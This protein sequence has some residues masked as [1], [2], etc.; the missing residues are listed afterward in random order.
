MCLAPRGTGVVQGKGD[1]TPGGLTSSDAVGQQIALLFSVNKHIASIASRHT[2]LVSTLH[3]PA[4]PSC[5]TAG[6]SL[7]QGSDVGG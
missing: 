4:S 1:A 3:Y 6:I 2:T 5:S 7:D